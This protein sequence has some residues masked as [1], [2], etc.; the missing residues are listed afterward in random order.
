[1]GHCFVWDVQVSKSKRIVGIGNRNRH[2][3][4]KTRLL[5]IMFE[6]ERQGYQVIGRRNWKKDAY[7]HKNTS[8]TI[9]LKISLFKR[10]QKEFRLSIVEIASTE[11]RRNTQWESV[12]M[13]NIKTFLTF[14]YQYFIYCQH[15]CSNNRKISKTIYNKLSKRWIMSI[16][17]AH[18]Q[19]RMVS[20]ALWLK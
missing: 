4:K 17:M 8:N 6:R 9:F 5:W 3:K 12:F 1:V 11:T 13:S 7:P 14:L 16:L 19:A 18:K 2:T 20:Q 10:I 15:C